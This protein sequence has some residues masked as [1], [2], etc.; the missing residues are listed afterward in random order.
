MNTPQKL[1]A[2][3]RI[4]ALLMIAAITLLALN[5]A[6]I[7]TDA[8]WTDAAQASAG[9][10]AITIPEV[11][12]PKCETKGSDAVI[13]WNPP[14]GGLPE[15]MRYKVTLDNVPADPDT[16]GVVFTKATSHTYAKRGTGHPH[17]NNTVLGVKVFVVIDSSTSVPGSAE[18]ASSGQPPSPMKIR[19]KHTGKKY[20]CE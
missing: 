20:D 11:V 18:W 7:Q 9:M 3:T 13:T 10:K 14:A 17:P 4:K 6:P 16:Q 2:G 8:A 12:G 5:P 15:G 1:T 19:Y